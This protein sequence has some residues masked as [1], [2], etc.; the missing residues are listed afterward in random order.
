MIFD[1]GRRYPRTYVHRNKYMERPEGFGQQGPSEIYHLLNKI[2]D[3]VEGRAEEQA[4][5][6]VDDYILGNLTYKNKTIYKSPPHITADNHFSG[7]NVL[8]YGGAKGYGL[9]LTCR[10]DRLPVGLKHYFRHGKE[11][12][13]RYACKVMRYENPI[14]AIKQV[15]ATETTKPYTKTHVSFQSTGSTNIRGVNNLP[16]CG[17]YVT[18]KS[19]GQGCNKRTW[20]IEQNEGRQTYL[21]TYYG[22]DNVD[23]MISIAGIRYTTWKYLL[24]RSILAWL[25]YCRNCSI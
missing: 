20:R 22:V 7:D 13:T 4:T 5:F 12:S 18:P 11:L 15:T 2:D 16:S 14:V 17:L 25:L 3:H 10:R 24:A 23:H 1:V 9:T 19:R 6:E 21:S 8:H